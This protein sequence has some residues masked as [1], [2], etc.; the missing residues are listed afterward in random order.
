MDANVK[1]EMQQL[2]QEALKEQDKNIQNF[3]GSNSTIIYQR[4]DNIKSSIE[5]IGRRITQ[6]EQ[7]VKNQGDKITAIEHSL[8]FTQDLIDSKTADLDKQWGIKLQQEVNNFSRCIYA[9]K[10]EADHFKNKLRILEDRNRRNN[11]RVD[12]I[13]ESENETWDECE[14][15]VKKF[16]KDAMNIQKEIDIERAHRMGKKKKTGRQEQ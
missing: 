9:A 16:L 3:I 14:E 4:L 5:D 7:T 12:G 11:L 10:E 13:K 6:V 2:I 1:S 8:E 15:K